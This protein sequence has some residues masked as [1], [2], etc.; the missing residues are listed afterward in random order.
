VGDDPV[1]AGLFEWMFDK[2]GGSW[3]EDKGLPRPQY[4]QVQGGKD[5]GVLEAACRNGMLP[6]V[7]YSRSPTGR[8]GGRRIAHM[9]SVVHCDDRWVGIL[10]NNYP[11]TIEWASPDELLRVSNPSGFWAVVLLNPGPPPV[12]RNPR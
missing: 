9:V 1:F 4:L 10:D 6:A 8:Y 7:T 5:L 2:P 11:Q 12:P 3:P